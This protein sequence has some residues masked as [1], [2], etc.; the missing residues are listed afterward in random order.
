MSTDWENSLRAALPKDLCLLVDE[1]FEMSQQICALAAI[2]VLHPTCVGP[3]QKSN[4]ILSC[5]KRGVASRAKEV[6]APLSSALV[7]TYLDYCV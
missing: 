3:V 7:R 2:K 4:C 5:I 6:T 1:K